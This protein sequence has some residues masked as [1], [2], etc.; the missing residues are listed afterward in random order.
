MGILS[1]WREAQGAELRREYEAAVARID[2]AS[3]ATKR[4]F[5]NNIALTASPIMYRCLAA[6][7]A[8]RKA[9][10]KE[11][12]KASLDMRNS[13]DWASALAL[14]ISRMNAE[15]RFTSGEGAAYVTRETDR[16][17]KE[18]SRRQDGD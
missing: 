4:V 13:G 5:L 8:K 17:I 12:R 10:L 2:G 11:M 3:E 14:E 9:F 18:A 1:K 15:S 16:L 7:P 6:S